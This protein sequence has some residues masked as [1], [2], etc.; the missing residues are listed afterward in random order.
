MKLE[1]TRQD[2]KKLLD[3]LVDTA[4][5]SEFYL[6]YCEGKVETYVDVFFDENEARDVVDKLNKNSSSIDGADYS[7]KTIVLNKRQ[8]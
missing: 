8:W 5:R 2:F 6:I 7:Y 1:S 4:K 3:F